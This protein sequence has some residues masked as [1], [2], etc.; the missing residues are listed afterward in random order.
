[1]TKR[2]S[3]ILLVDDD[4]T[5]RLLMQAALE[6]VNFVVISAENG[7]EAIQQF[8]ANSAEI[9]MVMLDV[10]M[11][12]MNG[13]EVCE[14]LRNKVGSKLPI[15]MVTGMDDVLSIDHAFELGATDFITKPVNWSLIHYRILYLK[16]AYLNLL[17]LDAA[18]AKNNA[19]LSA[20]PDTMVILNDR[21]EIVNVFSHTNIGD[22]GIKEEDSIYQFIS[23][24]V[25]KVFTDVASQS[26]TNG[27]VENFEYQFKS[28]ETKYF[29]GRFVAINEHEILCLIRDIT[30]RRDAENKIYRL[31][32]FDSLTGLPNRQSFIERLEGEIKLAKRTKDKLAILF[33]DLDG[34]KHINDTIGHN[35]GDIILKLTADRLQKSLR[36]SDLV[37]HNDTYQQSELARLGGDEFTI[38]LPN[39]HSAEDALNLA[40]RVRN[41]MS[42]SLQIADRDVLLT[43]SIG[44]AIYPEDGTD[45]ETLLKNADTA[46][47]HAKSEGRN[48]C[49]FYSCA[50]TRKAEERFNLE[51]NL[52]NALQ[53]NEFQLVYQPQFNL[54]SNCIESVEALIRWQHPQQGNISPLNFIPLAEEN[55]LIIP[56]G[57]WAIRAACLQAIEW[58]KKGKLLKVAVN[59]SPVQ[60]NPNLVTSV[61]SILEETNFPPDKLILEITENALMECDKN[62]LSTLNALREQNIS[63]ALD[64]FGTG[65]S[66]INYLTR[67]PLNTIKID[68]AFVH[69]M[70]EDKNSLTIVKAIISLS[71]NLGFSITAE[72][73]ETLEQAQALKYF[74]CDALQGY[75]FSKAV[76][77]KEI[78]TFLDK[79]WSIQ[80]V[81]PTDENV[82]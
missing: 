41:V 18:N 24:N 76:N 54:E 68:R 61:L 46:M 79:Q 49:Q 48:N 43:T 40:H 5:A 75:Y 30:D 37:I 64:D 52:R 19:I 51:S 32:Y 59:L 45:S 77:A 29:E 80:A 81:N 28:T 50:L 56:I 58:H 25:A 1:M 63:I 57:K 12:I 53:K 31:A 33:L 4:M 27:G 47:Y 44:I 8:E 20:I 13:Y 2:K 65:Y 11:P 15:I 35:T 36:S 38:I 62:I 3:T 82:A 10:E 66:S 7:Q 70:F 21:G 67:L 42:H 6:K 78:C 26:H 69:N 14:Y 34:F 9:E 17:D 16:R 72:G 71:K 60:F 23:D 74:G 39:L 22:L 55:G 73:I